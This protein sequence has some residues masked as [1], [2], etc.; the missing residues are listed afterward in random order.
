MIIDVDVPPLAVGLNENFLKEKVSSVEPVK[1]EIDLPEETNPD[2]VSY[3]L[4]VIY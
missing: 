4:A 1:M 3:M 2:N